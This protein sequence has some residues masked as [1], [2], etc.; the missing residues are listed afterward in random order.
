MTS[1]KQPQTSATHV[2]KGGASKRAANQRAKTNANAD[3]VT[4]INERAAR[5]A[6]ERE[7]ALA[8][9]E[10]AKPNAPKPSDDPVIRLKLIK[11]EQAALKAWQAGGEKGARPATP[12]FDVV[13]AGVAKPNGARKSASKSS[14]RQPRVT[15]TVE[16][17]TGHSNLAANNGR[18]NRLSAIAAR[19]KMSIVDLRKLLADAN[20]TDPETTRWTLTLPNGNVVGARL[21]GDPLPEKPA[22][23]AKSSKATKATK[24]TK[25]S[26]SSKSTTPAKTG[27]SLARAD[28]TPRPKKQ[29]TKRAAAKPAAGSPSAIGKTAAAAKS[30]EQRR[31][32]RKSA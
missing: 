29:T 30:I 27:K 25:S 28:V 19:N 31:N 2:R 14:D 7:A 23:A 18:H 1:K 13:V 26:K 24:A 3:K 9:I 21:P 12:N 4:A 8:R 10:S 11:E 32:A 15:V 6:A 22:K 17:F 20:I 5:E 16:F